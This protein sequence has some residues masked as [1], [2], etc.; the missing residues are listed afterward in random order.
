MCEQH[1]RNF[2]LNMR[3]HWFNIDVPFVSNMVK[4]MWDWKIALERI[5]PE[6]LS[7]VELENLIIARHD[8]ISDLNHN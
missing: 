2:S 1:E 8:I 5:W 6:A 3:K 4:M 7:H